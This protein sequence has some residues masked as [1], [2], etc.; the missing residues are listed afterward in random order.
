[1]L[2]SLR[3]VAWDGEA[4]DGVWLRGLLEAESE[5][6]RRLEIK[7]SCRWVEVHGGG[8]AGGDKA[9]QVDEANGDTRVGALRGGED[10][11]GGQEHKAA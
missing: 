10:G 8:G 3:R 9:G 7:Y 1:M 5:R 11:G 4:E 2:F 6:D